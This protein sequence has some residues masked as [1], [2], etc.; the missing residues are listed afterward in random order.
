[1][2]L[3]TLQ[4]LRPRLACSTAH[5]PQLHARQWHTLRTIRA[6]PSAAR[7]VPTPLVLLAA[8]GWARASGETAA[9]ESEGKAEEV[10]K[11]WAEVFGQNGWDATLLDVGVEAGQAA[12]GVIQAAEAG[13]SSR[14]SLA[15]STLTLDLCN[16]ELSKA[17]RTHAAFPPLLIA[18]GAAALI[19]QAYVSSAPLTGLILHDAPLSLA[20]AKARA[21][22]SPEDATEEFNFEA[23]FPAL[24]TWSG[25]ELAR[26]KDEGTPWYA[27][28]RLEE[29]REEEAGESL[30]RVRWELDEGGAK[31][32]LKWAEDE[33]M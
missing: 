27:V 19:A 24:C 15:N 25:A 14:S 26:Q 29:G 32:A 21:L 17:L 28:H 20:H 16:T 5:R 6:S 31:E 13:E 3:S 1:M 18:H 9:G 12:Q 2:L 8:P 33:G 30:E 22:L 10:F 7:R 11:Q 23:R 4:V